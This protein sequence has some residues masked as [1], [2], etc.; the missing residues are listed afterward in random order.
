MLLKPDFG[1]L[2][3]GCKLETLE[4]TVHIWKKACCS[5]PHQ[6]SII[7]PLFLALAS[8][9]WGILTSKLFTSPFQ[10]QKNSGSGKSS[11]TIVGR[12]ARS[13]KPVGCAARLGS[14][15]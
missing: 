14:L 5:K 2:K 3:R 8:I 15:F 1:S 11:N 13:L 6:N 9:V 7:S 12:Q 10:D 4:I